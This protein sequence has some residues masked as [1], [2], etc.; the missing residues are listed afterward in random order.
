[1]MAAISA[2]SKDDETLLLEKNEKLGKK[3]F[4]TGKGRCNVTNACDVT[5]FFDSVCSNPKFLYSAIYGFDNQSLMAFFEEAG[6]PLKT[7][8]GNRVFPVSDHSSD[9]IKALEKKLKSLS[10]S[11]YLN[12]TVTGIEIRDGE[13]AGVRCDGRLIRADRVIV[14]TGGLSYP[15]TGSTGDGYKWAKA[16]GHEIKKTY[17]SLV[18]F[19]LSDE[20][21]KELQG[22]TLKNVSLTL[23][24]GKKILYR[25]QGELLFTHFGISGPLVLS[26][27]SYAKGEAGDF[28]LY[29]DLKP[30]L[31]EDVL[32]KRLQREFDNAPSKSLYNVMK[33]LLPKSMISV[34]LDLAQTDRDKKAGQVSRAERE[35]LL[36]SLK[37]MPLHY[38]GVR[39]YNEAIITGGGVSVKD[40]D[41]STM[42]S[43]RIKGLYFCG[44]VLD[45]DALTGGYNLQI[46]FSTGHLAGGACD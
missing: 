16:T 38:E 12:T 23:Q 36:H 45:V 3:L 5:D 40:I 14:A 1:M 9:I 31:S 27:S 15:S 44:E 32:D 37:H 28:E 39:G 22:L 11:I 13:A 46:A 19:N 24:K 20:F 29:L 10:V 4:I 43:N 35:R 6:V 42:E 17:P 2:A 26:A 33:E 34:I 21:V 30:A 18:P 41:P 7:E 25:E 8:R